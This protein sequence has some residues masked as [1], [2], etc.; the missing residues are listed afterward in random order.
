[1]PLWR[2]GVL[3]TPYGSAAPS[4]SS[5]FRVPRLRTGSFRVRR[6]QADSFTVRLLQSSRLRT[7]SFRVPASKRAPSSEFRVV[8]LSWN[9]LPLVRPLSRL[10]LVRRMWDLLFLV[11]RLGTGSFWCADLALAFSGASYRI[12]FLNGAWQGLQAR[13]RKSSEVGSSL[14]TTAVA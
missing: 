3:V 8:R 7:G 1:M 9:W 5:S 13:R 12:S 10:L 6:L 4:R 14:G 11:R 2:G